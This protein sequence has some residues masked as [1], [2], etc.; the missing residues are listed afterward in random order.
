[1]PRWHNTPM[2][3]QKFTE[4]GREYNLIADAGQ[5]TV[6]KWDAD[7]THEWSKTFNQHVDAAAEYDREA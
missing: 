3:L 7:G 1:M 6:D 4:D 2:D 5:W